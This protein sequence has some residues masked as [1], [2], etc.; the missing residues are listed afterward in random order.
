MNL[1]DGV[2]GSKKY[3]IRLFKR[4]VL[5]YAVTVQQLIKLIKGASSKMQ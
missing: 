5:L 3:K 2:R 4:K 1:G